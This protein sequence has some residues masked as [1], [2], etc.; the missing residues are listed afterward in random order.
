MLARKFRLILK[1]K[2]E[3]FHRKMKREHLTHLISFCFFRFQSIQMLI[4][5]ISTC[6]IYCMLITLS[7]TVTAG[8]I[9]TSFVAYNK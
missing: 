6:F 4:L 3:I 8:T 5:I 9:K 2:N 7:F 1:K